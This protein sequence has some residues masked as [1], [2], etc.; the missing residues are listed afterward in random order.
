M[1]YFYFTSV[2][3]TVIEIPITTLLWC[4]TLLLTLIVCKSSFEITDYIIPRGIIFSFMTGV[5]L[6]RLNFYIQQ[7]TRPKHVRV[8][9]VGTISCKNQTE[10]QS[11]AFLGF[12]QSVDQEPPPQT[13][14]KTRNPS[15]YLIR[16]T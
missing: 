1:T 8:N 10:A 6:P 5:H 15:L 2:F 9:Q 12:E 7:N 16:N 3:L 4:L 11:S 14:T 13:L